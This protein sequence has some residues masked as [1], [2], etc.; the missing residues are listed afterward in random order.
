MRE[1]VNSGT[2]GVTPIEVPGPLW[3][4]YVFKLRRMG[5]DF[6]TVHEGRSGTFPGRHARYVLHGAVYLIEA[7]QTS[8]AA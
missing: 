5:L 4:A 8:E 3:S 6:E 1:L 2:R 7:D